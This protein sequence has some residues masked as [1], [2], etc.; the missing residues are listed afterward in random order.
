MTTKAK[1]IK[2]QSG[3]LGRGAEKVNVLTWGDLSASCESSNPGRE[4][5]LR[6]QE[7]AEAIVPS[8]SRWEG[9]N[10]EEDEYFE[11]LAGRTR[12]AACPG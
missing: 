12:K 3:K 2:G 10:V 11:E 9:L 6:R 1:T 5:R 4:I 8:P 7:S